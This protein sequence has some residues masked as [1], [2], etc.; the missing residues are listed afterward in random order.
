MGRDYQ[1]GQNQSL[2]RWMQLGDTTEA[3]HQAVA[4][5]DGD[6][7]KHFYSPLFENGL[8]HDSDK[9][10]P[11]D[12]SRESLVPAILNSGLWNSGT[13]SEVRQRFIDQWK[14]V[15]A[16]YLTLIFHYAQQPKE[17][18]IENLQ[19]FMREIKPEL[20]A[21]TAQFETEEALEAAS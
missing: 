10:T 18:V 17:S 11:V 8:P 5:Y 7:W 12:A 2:V 1:L 9:K 6:I 16:E 13:L 20:D 4:D 3:A 15:P 19:I 21:M 14:L